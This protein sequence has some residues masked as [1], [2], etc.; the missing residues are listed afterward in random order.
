MVGEMVSLLVI[1]FSLYCL[2]DVLV[3]PAASTRTLPKLVWLGL[4]VFV[5]VVGSTAWLFSGRP[6][7]AGLLPGSQRGGAGAT[8]RD[9]S[10]RGGG[11][12]RPQAAPRPIGPEDDPAFIRSLEERLRRQWDDR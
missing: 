5:P 4:V 11:K 6:H 1:G 2:F 7:G 3:S 10:L 8:W 9:V 12:G